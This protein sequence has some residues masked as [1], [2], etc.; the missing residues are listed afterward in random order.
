MFI[1]IHFFL[2]VKPNAGVDISQ[3]I[4]IYIYIY[5]TVMNQTLNQI[6]KG[7]KYPPLVSHYFSVILFNLISIIIFQI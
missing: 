6:V 4:T 1:V 3:Q 2:L 7:F 5:A